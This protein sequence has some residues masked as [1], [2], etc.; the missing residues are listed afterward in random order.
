MTLKDIRFSR[1]VNSTQALR[2]IEDFEG[3]LEEYVNLEI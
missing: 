3:L 1:L 2:F